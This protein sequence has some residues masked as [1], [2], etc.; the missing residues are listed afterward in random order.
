[1]TNRYFD[2]GAEY[3][4]AGPDDVLVRLTVSNRGPDAAPLHLLPT[5]WLRNTWSW[6]GSGENFP[7]RGDIVL[8]G[9]ATLRASH[10]TLGS[11]TLFGEVDGEAGA[12]TPLFTENETNFERVFGA[13]NVHPYVKDAFHDYVVHGHREP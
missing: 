11:F 10:A 4:K 5:L 9:A 7:P 6:G 2:V 12:P 1:M 8:D 13:P 3:A